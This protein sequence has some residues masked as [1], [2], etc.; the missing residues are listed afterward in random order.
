MNRA[1]VGFTGFVGSNLVKQASYSSLANSKNISD[2]YGKSFDELVIAAGDARKWFAN[3]NP[4]H[5]KSHLDSLFNDLT[6][7]RA[8]KVVLFSTVDVYDEQASSDEDVQC[9]SHEPYG[10]YRFYL[11]EKISA[12]FENV[13]VIRLPGLFG[14]GL[15]KNIIYDLIVGKDIS[16]F[17]PNSKFQWFCLDN[18]TDILEYVAKKNIKVLNVA[19]EPISVKELFTYLNVNTDELDINAKKIVYDIG[20]RY[21]R[22]FSNTNNYLYSKNKTLSLIGKFYKEETQ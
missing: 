15:K 1:L 3:Q 16:G 8:K 7:I 22:E 2:L 9:V 10:K 14:Q 5:Y 21:A 4:E 12:H 11:E 17:N 13:I 19:V 20:T 18:L 6:K